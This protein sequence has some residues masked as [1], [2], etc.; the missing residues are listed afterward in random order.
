MCGLALTTH[1]DK[2]EA[3]AAFRAARAITSADGLVKQVLALFDVLAVAD[4]DGILAGIRPAAA[5]Q[6]ET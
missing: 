2:S 4:D 3:T 1:A 5:G 6:G